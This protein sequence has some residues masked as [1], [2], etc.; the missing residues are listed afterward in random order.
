[1]E[2]NK[3]IKTSELFKKCIVQSS[4]FGFVLWERTI[5]WNEG[6]IIEE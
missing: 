1:M 5:V 3:M 4:L 2:M 6:C